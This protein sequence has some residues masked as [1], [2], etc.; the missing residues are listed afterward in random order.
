MLSDSQIGAIV[1]NELDAALSYEGEI[2]KKRSKLMDYY[3]TQ[4]YGDEVDGQSSVVTSDVSDVI[5]WMLPSLL[6]TFTQG[7]IIG[8]FDP[9][10]ADDED[11][12]QEKT[13]LSNHCFTVENDGVLTLHSMFKDALLQYTGTVKVYWDDTEDT[14]TTKYSGMSEIEYQSLLMKDN[15][16]IDN[17]ETEETPLGT[18]YSCEGVEIVKS[19][20]VKYDNIPPEEFLICKSARDFEDPTFIGHRS[21]KTRSQLIEMGFD[22][23]TVN[24]LPA[25]EYY[26]HSEQKNAR[27]HDYDNWQDINASRHTPN[28]I[29]YLGEY[30]MRVDVDEDGIAELWQILYA[31][32][33]VLSKEKVEDHPFCVVVPI[34]IP[35]RA[36]GSCPAE[37][38]ADIQFRKS[39]LVR[40][41]L[42]NVYQGNYPRILHSNSVELDDLLTPRA[43]GLVGVDTDVADVGGHA[44]AFVVPTMIEPILRAI[45]YTDTERE[46]RTGITRYSQGL[47]AE[48]LNKTAT[49]FLGIRDAS[50]QRLDLIARLFAD[51]GVRDIFKKTVD[52]LGRYQDDVKTIR[53]MGKPLEI[54][55]RQ[56]SQNA[57]CRIDVGIGSGDRQEKIMNLNAI[58]MRQLEFKDRNLVLTDQT[59]MYN[60]LEKLITEVGLKDVDQYFNNP[61]V[62][63]ETL[64]AQ[65]QQLTEMVQQMQAQLQQNP[66]AEAEMINARA[67]VS[68]DQMKAQNDMQQFLMK[69]EQDQKEFQADLAKQLTE[70]EL[71]YSQNVPGSVV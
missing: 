16:T 34:P 46:V 36:I 58:L 64:F 28:D 50:Q 21:P 17:M 7:K 40:Q 42:N 37:Q 57:N 62:P 49:G 66:L 3:N 25:D 5:E 27:Y 48:S 6:R 59:K 15:V 38:A 24:T 32:D 1:K 4:P 51:S 18:V 55:P 30:Y 11:E 67:K 20:G 70:L 65:N 68:T 8:Q 44:Q 26:E 22:K 54:D 2:A 33:K 29:V 12:A 23:D 45:E 71:K 56:W 60:T 39:T 41:M 35:H 63:E 10:T 31:G 69:M 52:L 53:V 9:L 13:F 47:D 43:G 19:G 14:V 61:E